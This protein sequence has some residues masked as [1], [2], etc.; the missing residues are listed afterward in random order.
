V[1]TRKSRS[2]H[3][4]YKQEELGKLLQEAR[5]EVGLRQVDLA[6]LLG[7]PQSYVSKFESGER[8]LTVPEL[9][10]ICKA[11]NISTANLIKKLE[12]EFDPSK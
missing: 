11:L 7:M 2:S 5:L 4:F 1:F 3:Y 6:K 9:I 8:T 12:Q 10:S